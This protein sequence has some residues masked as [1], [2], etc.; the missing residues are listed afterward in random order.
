MLRRSS[1]RLFS[2]NWGKY[3]EYFLKR[4]KYCMK[5]ETMWF[6]HG[7]IAITSSLGLVLAKKWMMKGFKTKA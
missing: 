4:E 3:S 1:E 2:K 5:T 6:I 7:L